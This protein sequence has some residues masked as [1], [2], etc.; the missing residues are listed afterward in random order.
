[1][2]TV[3]KAAFTFGALNWDLNVYVCLIDFFFVSHWRFTLL[4]LII[5]TVS[6]NMRH[7]GF[8]L[9][10]GRIN[11]LESILDLKHC[12]HCPFFSLSSTTCEIPLL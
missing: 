6:E 12:I 9:H 1:M 3:D 8:K 10:M 5:A 2:F 7:T 11:M 4:L